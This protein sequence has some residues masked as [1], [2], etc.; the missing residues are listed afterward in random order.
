MRSRCTTTSHRRML[1]FANVKPTSARS[2]Q[3]H[4]SAI[5]AWV[6]RYRRRRVRWSGAERCL[7]VRRANCA[8]CASPQW[9]NVWLPPTGAVDKNNNMMVVSFGGGRP[10]LQRSYMLL[11]VPRLYGGRALCW[12]HPAFAMVVRCVGGRPPLQWFPALLAASRLAWG[13]PR[14]WR[15]PAL[16]RE[17]T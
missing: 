8:R 16:P 4:W 5:N 13:H 14:C 3:P 9:Y 15:R 7:D 11:A 12:R 17:N 2:W 6:H 10:P 1:S